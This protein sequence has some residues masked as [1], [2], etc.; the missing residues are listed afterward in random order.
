MI[1]EQ[2]NC[3]DKQS[4]EYSEIYEKINRT[5]CSTAFIGDSF[6]YLKLLVAFLIV[7]ISF[8]I[9]MQFTSFL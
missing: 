3:W 1:K 4:Y 9:T 8:K 5:I 2:F 6:A 7:Q